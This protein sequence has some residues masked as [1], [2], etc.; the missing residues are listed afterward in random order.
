MP[1]LCTSRWL[2]RATSQPLDRSHSRLHELTDA[3]LLAKKERERH[4]LAKSGISRL[5]NESVRYRR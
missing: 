2:T 5:K 4:T 3:N 1:E